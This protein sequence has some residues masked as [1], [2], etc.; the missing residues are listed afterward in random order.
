MWI[1]T[2]LGWAMSNKFKVKLKI[3]GFELEIEG[4]REDAAQISEQIGQQVAGIMK[5]VEGIIE[6]SPA[7]K[8][9]NQPSL[10]GLEAS[11]VTP[12]KPKRKKRTANLSGEKKTSTDPIDFVLKDTTYSTP[13]QSWTIVQKAMWL[14]F[15]LKE[16]GLGNQHSGSVLNATF[17]KHFKEAGTIDTGNINK[18]LMKK[19]SEKRVGQ[20]TTNDPAEWF[21]IQDGIN[22]V[23]EL[24]AGANSSDEL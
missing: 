4:A 22:E 21:L 10:P 9:A 24:I 8:P 17:N 23:R 19:K 7:E 16:L 6:G 18:Q 5:P 20:D 12:Q 15:I 13:Q 1:R 2:Q 14:L 3:Q 11:P